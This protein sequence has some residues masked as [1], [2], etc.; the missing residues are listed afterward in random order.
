MVHEVFH[1]LVYA[2]TDVDMALAIGGYMGPVKGPGSMDQ[3]S[4]YFSDEMNKH[5][6]YCK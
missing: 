2:Y 4:D 3:A 6:S 1:G 5:C